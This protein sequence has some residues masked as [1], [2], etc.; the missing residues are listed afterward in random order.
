[1]ATL[2]PTTR[3]GTAAQEPTAATSGPPTTPITRPAPPSWLRP[4]TSACLVRGGETRGSETTWV[5]AYD[6]QNWSAWDQF[7]LNTVANTPPVATINDHTLA[8]QPVVSGQQLDFVFRCQRQPCHLL[9]V[10]GQRRRS[11]QRLLLD[12]LTTPITRPAP[13]SWLRPSDLGNVWVRGGQVDGSE[14]MWVAA[15]D[16]TNWGNWDPFMLWTV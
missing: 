12:P 16:G 8:E 1:M 4:R 6:G 13:P 9:R 10:L 7:N 2:P 11:R 15:Y 5:A 14:T 3:F